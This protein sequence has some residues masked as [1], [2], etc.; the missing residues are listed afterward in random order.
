MP[1]L[2]VWKLFQW[3]YRVPRE[4]WLPSEASKWV[5]IVPF[6]PFSEL[7]L[8]SSLAAGEW[9]HIFCQDF[10][11]F[12]RGKSTLS[13]LRH[14]LSFVAKPCFAAEMSASNQRSVGFWEESW[15]RQSGGNSMVPIR[16]LKTKCS[17]VLLL[18]ECNLSAPA[19][20]QEAG[21]DQ[22]QPSQKVPVAKQLEEHDTLPPPCSQA[23]C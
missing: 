2:A 17:C 10:V 15:G 6:P 21:T 9:G 4:S 16:L 3:I 12:P 11:V 7:S 20:P 18:A 1:W 22:S 5:H 14:F 19:S 8:F 23:H 13:V